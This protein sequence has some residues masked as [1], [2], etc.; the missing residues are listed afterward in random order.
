MPARKKA[1]LRNQN[2]LGSLK[3][4]A[5]PKGDGK[6]ALQIALGRVEA[7]TVKY[8]LDHTGKLQTKLQPWSHCYLGQK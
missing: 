1:N 7:Y 8:H 3:Y 6:S 2:K 4:S 5:Y